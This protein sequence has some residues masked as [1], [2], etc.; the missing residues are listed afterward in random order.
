M[1]IQYDVSPTV[2]IVTSAIVATIG[3]L[4]GAATQFTTLFGEAYSKE[5]VAALSL[6]FIGFGTLNAALFAGSSTKPGPL[7]TPDK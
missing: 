6:A 3:A 7:A 5:I 2:G 1:K 4:A